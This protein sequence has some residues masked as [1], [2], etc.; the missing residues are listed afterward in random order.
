MNTYFIIYLYYMSIL[1][2]AITMIILDSIYL[3]MT[4][5]FYNNQVRLVQG[6]DIQIKLI[7][8]VLTYVVLV[9]GLYYFILRNKRSVKEAML[10][11]FVIYA[12]F[13]LTNMAIFNK[14]SAVSVV[15]DTMWGSVLFGTTTYVAYHFN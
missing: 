3:T 4:K 15:L 8:T 9:F 7:P 13:E 6:S 10:L 11:G 1:V 14:W 2:A 12:V 5:S